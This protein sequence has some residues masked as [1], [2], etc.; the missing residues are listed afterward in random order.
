M[1]AGLIQKDSGTIYFSEKEIEKNDLL[2]RKHALQIIEQ[3][4][5]SSTNSALTVQ[6]IIAEPSVILYGKTVREYRETVIEYAKL[7]GLD[8]EE[9]ML[10]KKA[11]ELSGGQRQRTA[12]ARALSM[13]PK[14]LLADEIT[15]MLDDSSK[16][17][18]MRLLKRLQYEIGF[19]MLMVTHDTALVKKTAD[20][21]YCMEDGKIVKEGSVRKIFCRDTPVNHNGKRPERFT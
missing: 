6:E 7:V 5:F 15:S 12:I 10:T 14:L 20:Y 4:S 11:G 3:D 17:N 16:A 18:I 2:T 19:S 8:A 9:K 13:Q 21:V 1:I